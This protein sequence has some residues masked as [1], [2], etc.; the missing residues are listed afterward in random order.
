MVRMRSIDLCGDAAA[1]AAGHPG[2]L[3]VVSAFA[4]EVPEIHILRPALAD[5]LI[6]FVV[7]VLQI[8]QPDHQPDRQTRA[9]RR[10][11]ASASELRCRA[12]PLGDL[13]ADAFT[14]A[15]REHWCP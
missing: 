6:T 2:R 15:A 8:A 1:R 14:C 9:A 12:E 5:R 11:H 13:A 10:A 4:R 7:R 3:D